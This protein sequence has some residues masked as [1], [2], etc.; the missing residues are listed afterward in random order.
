VDSVND[1]FITR[2]LDKDGRLTGIIS[3]DWK[4]QKDWELAW[5]DEIEGRIK[6]L[7][8]KLNR[9]D[10]GVKAAYGPGPDPLLKVANKALEREYN[11]TKKEKEPEERQCVV[12]REIQE[13]SERNAST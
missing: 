9:L 13:H 1:K 12:T 7:K 11:D 4:A 10:A 2:Q 6:K 8:E 3:I 5:M